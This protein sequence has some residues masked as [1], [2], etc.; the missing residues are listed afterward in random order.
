MLYSHTVPGWLVGERHL[1][2]LVD[3]LCQGLIEVGDAG[4]EVALPHRREG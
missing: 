1:R 2:E 4:V 3:P